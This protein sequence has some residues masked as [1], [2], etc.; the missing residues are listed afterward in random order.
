MHVIIVE[1][2]AF[3]H[4]VLVDLTPTEGRVLYT[5]LCTFERFLITIVISIIMIVIDILCSIFNI[6]K[7]WLWQVDITKL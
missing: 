6:T 3:H 7:C 2:L 4:S 5:K 1:S